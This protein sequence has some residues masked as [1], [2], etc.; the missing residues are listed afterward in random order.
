[1]SA[2]AATIKAGRHDD[3][4]Q[5]RRALRTG[6]ERGCWLYIPFEQLA[7]TGTDLAGPPPF[8]R[9]WAGARGRVVVQLYAKQ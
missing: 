3:H 7:R 8:Y 4:G 9:V 5:R 1:V 2:P 6:R